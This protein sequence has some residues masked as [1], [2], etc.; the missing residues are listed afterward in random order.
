MQKSVLERKSIIR[1][2]SGKRSF[3]AATVNNSKLILLCKWSIWLVTKKKGK[4]YLQESKYVFVD[5]VGWGSFFLSRSCAEASSAGW[6]M[7]ECG[8]ASCS[9]QQKMWSQWTSWRSL[10][11][12]FRLALKRRNQINNFLFA[13]N[14]SR[15]HRCNR[16]VTVVISN[17][18]LFQTSEIKKGL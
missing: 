11:S 4:P 2:R 3:H 12:H 7:V 5:E 14:L 13:P 9:K 17:Y 1:W 6:K 16:K 18:R 15:S 10:G 8:L